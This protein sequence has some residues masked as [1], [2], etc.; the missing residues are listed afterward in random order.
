M[1]PIAD[2]HVSIPVLIGARPDLD[3]LTTGTLPVVP[4]I[5]H[6][7]SVL[8]SALMM[9]ADTV[10]GMR[11][12]ATYPEWT[13]TTDFS[14]RI[15]KPIAAGTVY[16]KA[17]P[18][19]AG[20]S[21]VV[22]ELTMV[23]HAG[24]TVAHAEITFM[25]T[26]LRG[27]EVKLDIDELKRHMATQVL[28]ELTAPIAEVAGID[29][30]DASAGVVRLHPHDGVRR[31]G[32]F[33]Q[34]SIMTL[35]GEVSAQTLAAAHHGGTWRAT[36]MDVRYLMGGRVGPLQT[37]AHWLGD[38]ADGRIA[39]RA[40]DHGSEGRLTTTYLVDVAPVSA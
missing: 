4:H 6:G 37:E 15:T 8:A 39:V 18:L 31:P 24:A 1:D 22:E 29:V 32:G 9:L 7:G 16:A 10:V 35:L 40:R 34:G 3:D 25:R 2:A 17:E 26:P 38:P 12:E 5:T 20:R 27:D 36:G 14:L 28:P 11:L 19:R 23:D 13:F 30:G 21:L 33:V